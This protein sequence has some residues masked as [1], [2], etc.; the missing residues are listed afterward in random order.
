MKTRIWGPAMGLLMLWGITA[1]Q[2]GGNCPNNLSEIEQ[3][4]SQREYATGL[5]KINDAQT[6][7][8]TCPDLWYQK[9]LALELQDSFLAAD[10]AYTEVLRQNPTPCPLQV[11]ALTGRGWA[12][13]QQ[14]QFAEASADFMAAISLSGCSDTRQ[15]INW[16]QFSLANCYL[17]LGQFSDAKTEL[18]SLLAHSADA[19]ADAFLLRSQAQLKL[20]QT[21]AAVDDIRTA[22]TKGAI[23]E[24][25][26]HWRLAEC[27]FAGNLPD[28]ACVHLK[29][30]QALQFP[31]AL[32]DSRCP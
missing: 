2:S 18:D 7:Y 10:R 5:A 15:D 1:C 13:V 23:P 26:F 11:D 28:S 31:A 24:A 14:R 17:E 16:L 9:G 32:T 29:A 8:G 12:K 19:Y 22:F 6:E 25:A 3:A 20:N 27:F 21:Q 4:I 30:A